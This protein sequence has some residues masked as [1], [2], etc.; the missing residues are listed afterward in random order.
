MKD[1]IELN[2]VFHKFIKLSARI[3]ITRSVSYVPDYKAHQI[4]R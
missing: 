4:I 3:Y 1:L 2:R